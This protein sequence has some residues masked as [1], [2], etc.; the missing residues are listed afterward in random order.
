MGVQDYIPNG[1]VSQDYP[2]A[3]SVFHLASVVLPPCR[4]LRRDCQLTQI[5]MRSLSIDRS[6]QVGLSNVTAP[7][8][9]SIAGLRA[10]RKFGLGASA[11][12]RISPL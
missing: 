10:M 8:A 5:A 6:S 3:V 4:Q 7:L 2:K 1:D 12:A 11:A 9:L